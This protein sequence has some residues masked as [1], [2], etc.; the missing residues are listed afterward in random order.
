[1]CVC[2]VCVCVLIEEVRVLE[3]LSRPMMR[4]RLKLSTNTASSILGERQGAVE[5]KEEKDVRE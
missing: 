3:L 5:R 4:E 1:M 2:S